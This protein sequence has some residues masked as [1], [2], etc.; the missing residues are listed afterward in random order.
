MTSSRYLKNSKHCTFIIHREDVIAQ[1][2]DECNFIGPF[3]YQIS[4]V[5]KQ[6]VEQH[7]A[8]D[9]YRIYGDSLWRT[10][11][12]GLHLEIH[13]TYYISKI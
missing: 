4:D 2:F 5:F 8:D 10:S 6:A 11:A 1:F 13:N 12:C 3:F 9:D 7:P